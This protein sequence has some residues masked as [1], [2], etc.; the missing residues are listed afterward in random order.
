[1]GR[2]SLPN[3]LLRNVELLVGVALP[4]FLA[5]VWLQDQLTGSGHWTHPLESGFFEW[6]A[7]V[8]TLVLLSLFHSVGLTVVAAFW[9]HAANRGTALLGSLLLVPLL[10]LAGKPIGMLARYSVP[11]AAGV[12][13]YA[14]ASRV[15]GAVRSP[16]D[17]PEFLLQP[18]DKMFRAQRPAVDAARHSPPS[19][20]V[21]EAP[22]VRES[23]LR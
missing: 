1:M 16:E 4:L 20:P 12:V 7:L 10:V 22:A 19:G 11:L 18:E 9:P 6:L 3:D 17:V 2:R 5:L 8:P 14:L 13:V 23:P 21:L 15:P